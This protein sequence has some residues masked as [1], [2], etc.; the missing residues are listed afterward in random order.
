MRITFVLPE[1]NLAGGTRVVAIYA[2]RLRRRGH[3]VTVV[4]PPLSIPIK[5]KIKSF[6]L[7]RGWPRSRLESAYFDR[8]GVTLRILDRL[9]AV[10]D[11]DVPDGDLVVATFYTTAYW[12]NKLSP[13][14][15]AKAIFIQNYEVEEGGSNPLLDATWQMPMHKITISN[16]LVDLAAKRFEDAKVS[17]VPNSVDLEQFNA[18]FRGKQTIPTVGLLY[19]KSWFKGCST[20]L[21]ALKQLSAHFPVVRVLCFGAEHPGP[22]ALRLP[23]FAQ[24]HFRP[25]QDKLKDIYSQCDVW[26]CGSNR[27]G[28]HLPPLE[29]MACRCPV[30]STRVGGPADI[31]ADGVNGYLVE[32]GNANALYQRTLQVL[33]LPPSDWEK[34]SEAAYRTATHYTW[35]DAT[36]LMEKA[37]LLAIARAA[38]G[39]LRASH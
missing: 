22:V 17:L 3:E 14:K 32:I 9:K 16:W 23:S 28:F 37:M 12:V 36:D 27:E 35:D 34:M 30:V 6:V 26:M 2:N 25:P 5:R 39:E 19:S 31:V 21:V 8:T 10:E 18:V 29:A 1:V 24:F 15:G 13:E 38:C 4:A 20:S 7:G 11:Q 33:N